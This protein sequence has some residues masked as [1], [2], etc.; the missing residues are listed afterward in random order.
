MSFTDL[1]GRHTVV[2]GGPSGTA[3][4]ELTAGGFNDGPC[5]N[6]PGDGKYLR[7]YDNLDD[8]LGL[9][10]Y[11]IEFH[12]TEIPASLQGLLDECTA[13]AVTELPEDD[14]AWMARWVSNG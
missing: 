2:V 13:H 1:T 4:T 10:Q 5:I 9:D 3:P 14:E 8:F 6:F 12:A 11:C 7:V